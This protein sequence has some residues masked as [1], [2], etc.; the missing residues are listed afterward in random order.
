[1]AIEMTTVDH[2]TVEVKTN[3]A[4]N[5]QPAGAPKLVVLVVREPTL[6]MTVTCMNVQEAR[7]LMTNLEAVI[8]E[9]EGQD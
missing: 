5:E 4:Y 3:I 2:T 8:D 7:Q 1:M 9:L 6:E